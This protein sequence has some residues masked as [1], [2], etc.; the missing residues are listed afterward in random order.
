M[1]YTELKLKYAYKDHSIQMCRKGK[2]GKLP[3]SLAPYKGITLEMIGAETEGK[4]QSQR[5]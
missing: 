5:I 4:E 2:I 3:K 1:Y